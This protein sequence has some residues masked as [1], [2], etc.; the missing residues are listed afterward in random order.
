MG[1]E[2]TPQRILARFLSPARQFFRTG[3]KLTCYQLGGCYNCRKNPGLSLPQCQAA[4]LQ[5]RDHQL[6]LFFTR[7]FKKT[8]YRYEA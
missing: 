7:N 5:Y 4:R 6:S 1:E 3:E 8:E 2:A